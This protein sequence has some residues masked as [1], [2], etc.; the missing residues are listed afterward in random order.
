[1][2]LLRILTLAACLSLSLASPLSYSA[3][4]SL[5]SRQDASNETV[6]DAAVTS[7]A[8]PTC[9]KEDLPDEPYNVSL[10][11]AALFTIFSVSM[12]GVLL[13]LG[14]RAIE[15]AKRRWSR[16]R[17]MKRDDDEGHVK[18]ADRNHSHHDLS[19][20]L[21]LQCA[22]LFGAGVIL[23]T[24]FIHMLS[25]AMEL[26]TNPCLSTFFTETYRS[27]AAAL[28]VF[29]ALFTHLIQLLA[30]QTISGK[31]GASHTSS[32]RVVMNREGSK[33]AEFLVS[34]GKPGI[35]VEEDCERMASEVR[36]VA[37]EEVEDG[38]SMGTASS[39]LDNSKPTSHDEHLHDHDDHHF[40]ASSMES[41]TR[42]PI[43]ET[44][45]H[46][47]D[48]HG[49]HLILVK[50]KRV[51]TYILELGIATHS[52]IIG[53]ALG[54]TRGSAETRTLMAALSFHQFFE[55]VALSTVVMET[56][57]GRAKGSK[58]SLFVWGMVLFYV[59]TTPIGVGI[60]IAL[61][62]SYNESSTS[63]LLIQGVLEALSA[64]IL[65]YDG[66]VNILFMH[67]QAP[68]VK[69]QQRWKQLAQVAS[70]WIGALGMAIVGAWAP[71]PIPYMPLYNFTGV[72]ANPNVLIR[73]DITIPKAADA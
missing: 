22:K 49:H 20:S 63:T 19:P 5:F 34:D 33:T 35:V 69:R 51:A 17:R 50:E 57:A 13:P 39:S 12:L 45:H 11:V 6:A 21:L 47:E 71:S 4:H 54:V 10:H 1:M 18:V 38:G 52:I 61:G 32:G 65:A 23:A 56:E 14:I 29:G 70:V 66:L 9:A 59:L 44:H 62:S 36:T 37:G 25:P 42:T 64:G 2:Q 60:G 40:H 48:E 8:A 53:L 73:V 3:A 28:A 16:N 58:G 55:G 30:S 27:S 43:E 31:L 26:L 41:G 7:D 24:A 46:N 72:L 15:N 67:F 68:L